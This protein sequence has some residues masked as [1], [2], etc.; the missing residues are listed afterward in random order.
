MRVVEWLRNN[1]HEAVHLREERLERLANGEIFVKAAREKRV[2]LTFDLDFGEIVAFSHDA[3]VSVIVFRLR[4]TRA[5]HVI[6]RLASVLAT[7]GSLLD[8]ACV[9][10]VEESRHR[11]RRFPS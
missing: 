4:N 5:A 2:V 1:G 6:D 9:I 3:P 10:A 11:V 8:T 7:A